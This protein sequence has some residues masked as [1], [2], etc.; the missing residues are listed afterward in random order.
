[1]GKDFDK[2]VEDEY[3]RMEGFIEGKGGEVKRFI[4][5]II[6]SYYA[7]E[8]GGLSYYEFLSLMVELRKVNKMGLII[9]EESDD[10]S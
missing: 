6:E 7:E 2:T 3:Q 10:R 4:K 1:M 9:E 8:E 5:R